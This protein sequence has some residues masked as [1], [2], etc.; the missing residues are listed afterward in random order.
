MIFTTP[1]MYFHLFHF[2]ADGNCS[3][4]ITANLGVSMSK[5]PDHFTESQGS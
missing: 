4:A 2:P 5:H 3:H 1:D